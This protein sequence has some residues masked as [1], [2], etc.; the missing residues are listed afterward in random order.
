MQLSTDAALSMTGLFEN[1][2]ATQL[3]LVAAICQ[4]GHYEKGHILLRENDHSD[5]LYV[6]VSGGVEILIS[7]A[8]ISHHQDMQPIVVA[9]LR[10][11]DIL[12]EVT[13]VD[14]GLRTATARISHKHAHILR[15]RRAQLMRLCDTYPELGYKI[16]R[17]LA[18]ELALKLRQSDLVIREYQLRLSLPRRSE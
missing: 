16:M 18:A 9:E 13:L 1:L 11:G 3:A 2:T 6:I 12:G 4:P 14:E 7:P 10:A 5:E 15:I 17:N 8:M